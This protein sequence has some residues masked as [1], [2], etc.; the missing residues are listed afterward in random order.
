M[1]LYIWMP[2]INNMYTNYINFQ[3]RSTDKHLT[4]FMHLKTSSSA[5]R[6]RCPLSAKLK[7]WSLVA[8]IE[9]QKPKAVI[10]VSWTR[11]RKELLRN[12]LYMRWHAL[13]GAD[14]SIDFPLLRKCTPLA[15]TVRFEARTDVLASLTLH[16]HQ[17]QR[18][19]SAILGLLS[20]HIK[21]KMIFFQPGSGGTLL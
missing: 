13:A 10:S 5:T 2:F 16:L 14:P 11:Q 7:K 9:A 17:T 6:L 12:I 18:T 20:V 21:L 8:L 3:Q 4:P 19:V 1:A 15:V